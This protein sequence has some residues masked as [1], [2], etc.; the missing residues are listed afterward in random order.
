M[1]WLNIALAVFGLA[2]RAVAQGSVGGDQSSCSAS[3]NFVYK[4]CYDDSNNG[5]HAGFDWQ[6][7]T[8]PADVKYYP[9]YSGSMTVTFCLSVCRGHGFEWAAIYGTDCHCAPK[10]PMP[11]NPSSVSSGPQ[12]PQGSAP[13]TPAPSSNTDCDRVCPGD[14]SQICAGGSASRVYFDPSYTNDTAQ[15]GAAGNYKYFGC[16]NNQNP[17]PMYV[18]SLSTTSTVNCVT[19]CGLLGY[20]FS[21]R[22]GTDSN[23]GSTCGCGSEIQT[24]L[25]LPE[26][27][28]NVYCNG[29]Q[30]AK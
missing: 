8:N 25:Q 17:G 12:P 7:S 21:S 2:T 11:S 18:S 4:G 24:G 20:A 14:S 9:G 1:L 10:F 15:A 6:F 22:S 13:G 23:T 3:Q 27:S 16:Y 5:R 29:T 26:S 30:G 28:C 19:Y